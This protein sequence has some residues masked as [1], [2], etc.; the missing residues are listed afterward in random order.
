MCSGFLVIDVISL[1]LC[2]FLLDGSTSFVVGLSPCT[3][4]GQN[5]QLD[6][7][8]KKSYKRLI[9]RINRRNVSFNQNFMIS[10]LT[11]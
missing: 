10:I 4:L 5:Y 7:N 2:V 11:K 6:I 3:V 9:Y 1:L 8:K